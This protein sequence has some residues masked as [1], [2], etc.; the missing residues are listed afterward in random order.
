MIHKEGN[1][2]KKRTALVLGASGLVGQEVT[3]LLLAS[4]RYQSVTVLVRKKLD[5]KH[6]K[7]RQQ[8]VDFAALEQYES[9]FFRT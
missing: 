8:L 3:R 6:E 9:V 7:L 1:T 5:W 2:W 4:S